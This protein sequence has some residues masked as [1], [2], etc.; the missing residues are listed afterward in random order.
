MAKDRIVAIDLCK[1]IATLFVINSHADVM[2]PSG[3]EFLATGGLLEMLC[4]SFAQD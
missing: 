1:A 2:Y 3:Y 4:F